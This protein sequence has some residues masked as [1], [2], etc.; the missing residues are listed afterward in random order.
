MDDAGISKHEKELPDLGLENHNQC[1]NPDADKLP[2]YLAQQLHLEC[3]D[4]LP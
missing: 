1:D 4:H 2:E 3:F